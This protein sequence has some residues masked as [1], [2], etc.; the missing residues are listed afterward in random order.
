MAVISPDTHWT[1]GHC[2]LWSCASLVSFPFIFTFFTVSQFVFTYIY[3]FLLFIFF[4]LEVAWLM[5][6]KLND[7]IIEEVF[8]WDI[9]NILFFSSFW[10]T[11]L[12]I[13]IPALTVFFFVFFNHFLR[14]CFSHFFY[15][16][17][18]LFIYFFDPTIFFS[19]ASTLSFRSVCSPS[20]LIIL[21][22]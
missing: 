3:L 15:L 11:L 8:I 2:A 16:L 13:S 20:W 18:F 17:K 6:L 4:G 21:W 10:L 19:R 14:H 7:Y 9:D 12:F 22:L 1:S 5:L